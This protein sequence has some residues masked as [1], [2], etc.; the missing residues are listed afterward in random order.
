MSQN[1]DRHVNQGDN[2]SNIMVLDFN[3]LY[4]QAMYNN[5]SN[6]GIFDH[7]RSFRIICFK[8]SLN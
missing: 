2:I 6:S 1:T 5:S 4:A 7:E 3:H 8:G